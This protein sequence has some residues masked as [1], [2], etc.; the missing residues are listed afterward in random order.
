[1]GFSSIDT[2]LTF[3][4]DLQNAVLLTKENDRIVFDGHMMFAGCFGH[5]QS[6]SWFF[7]CLV[8]G[9]EECVL[10]RQNCDV[11]EG[12]FLHRWTNEKPDYFSSFDDAVH[13]SMRSYNAKWNGYYMSSRSAVYPIS[14]NPNDNPVCRNIQDIIEKRYIEGNEIL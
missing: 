10:E 8:N 7:L 1:M 12:W 3:V 4:N 11:G 2:S 9:Q 14:I 13:K 5:Y 6:K